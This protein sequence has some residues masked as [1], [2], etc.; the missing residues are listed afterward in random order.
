VDTEVL[1]AAGETLTG[2]KKEDF[3]VFDEGAEQPVVSFSFEAEPLDLILL[4][5]ASGS[6][7]SKLL[8]VVRAVELG[9]HELKP[10]DRVCVMAFH[11]RGVEIAPFTDDLEAV[12]QTV[13]LKVPALRFGGSS[14]PGRGVADAALRFRREPKGQRRRAVL[15]V[16]DKAGSTLAGAQA[17]V[18]ELWESDAVMSELV[19]GKSAD[20]QVPERGGSIVAGETGGA[21]VVAGDP[22]PSFQMAVRL[23]RRRYTLYYA[24]PGGSPGSER[25]IEVRSSIA[26]ARV[27]ARSGYVVR[28]E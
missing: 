12:N 9:F 15:L 2:L 3:R 26:G 16:T 4:F 17:A 1:D 25:R 20:T 28:S 22:G 14:N 7:R 5:D 19:I 24:S 13:A 23:L 10:G 6:M 11:T 18:R 27:R 21:T 8:R